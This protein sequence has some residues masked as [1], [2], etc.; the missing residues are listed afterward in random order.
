MVDALGDLIV[1]AMGGL[2]ILG[3]DTGEVVHEIVLRNKTRKYTK[4]NHY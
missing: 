4:D 3:E 1:W 2:E